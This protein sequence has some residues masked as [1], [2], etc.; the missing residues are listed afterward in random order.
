MHQKTKFDHMPTS[1]TS[2]SPEIQKAISLGLS[3]TKGV[4]TN[5]FLPALNV[6]KGAENRTP[7]QLL[8]SLP[9]STVTPTKQEEKIHE[10]LHVKHVHPMFHVHLCPFHH[11]TC[12]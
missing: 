2:C 3:S 11:L 6:S 1:K 8:G 5:S 9:N 7:N 4:Q 12:P 10:T